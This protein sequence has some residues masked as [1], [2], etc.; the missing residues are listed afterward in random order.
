MASRS[1]PTMSIGRIIT[2]IGRANLD[3]TGVDQSSS[4]IRRPGR[5]LQRGRRGRRSSRRRDPPPD[6]TPPQTKIIKGA[7]NK[8]EKNK[9]KFK[10]TSSE[11][12][13]TFECELVKRKFKP[14]ASPKTIK[15]LEPGQAQVQGPGDRRSRQRRYL[16]RQRQVQGRWAWLEPLDLEPLERRP[17]PL[18][19]L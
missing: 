2:T 13:S 8:T 1:T 11:P 15:S 18:L 7:P 17:D 5:P 19:A 14:C 4:A 9:V 6:T 10:F 12:D 3:G 16:A